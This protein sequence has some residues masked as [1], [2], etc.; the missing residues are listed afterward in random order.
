MSEPPP[1]FLIEPQEGETPLRAIER[2][3]Y[4]PRPVHE[5]LAETSNIA[6]GDAALAAELAALRTSWEVRPPAASGLLARL[7]TRLAWWLCG[8]ELQ[9]I[10]T[11]HATL[12]RIAASLVSHID[13]ERAARRRIEE[14]LS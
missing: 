12:S 14:Q 11:A 1:P 4:A 8:P 7:R 10:N 2:A 3:L 6:L 5:A 13:A 9:Q